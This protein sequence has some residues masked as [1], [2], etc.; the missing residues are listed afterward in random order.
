ML[1][2]LV[3]LLDGRNLTAGGGLIAP[4]QIN[5]APSALPRVWGLFFS[6]RDCPAPI[7]STALNN[8]VSWTLSVALLGC[9]DDQR[10][11]PAPHQD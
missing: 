11:C 10:F 3:L 9:V 7:A 8:T 2:P 4:T 5:L 1:A 6:A